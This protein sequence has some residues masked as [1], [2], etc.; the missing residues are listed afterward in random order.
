MSLFRTSVRFYFH[1]ILK[2]LLNRIFGMKTA[3]FTSHLRN[4][5]LDVI[6]LHY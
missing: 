5:I 3:I 2:L 6:T 4:V 1:M